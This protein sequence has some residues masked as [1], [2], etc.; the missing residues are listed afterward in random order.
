MPKFILKSVSNT[1]SFWNVYYIALSCM[2][3]HDM[4]QSS[5]IGF[6]MYMVFFNLCVYWYFVS[7]SP[8]IRNTN[9]LS[10]I[11]QISLALLISCS[12]CNNYHKLQVLQLGKNSRCKKTQ[13]KN[14]GI[15]ISVRSKKNVEW[16]HLGKHMRKYQAM[17]EDF[18]RRHCMVSFRIDNQNY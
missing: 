6:E 7:P 4:L 11:L 16:Y 8:T 3:A 12:I 9:R 10:N 2:K 18:W 14:L 13:T 1:K 15:Q 17:F 5:H